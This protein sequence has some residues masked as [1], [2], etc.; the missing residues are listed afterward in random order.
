MSQVVR[1]D[2]AHANQVT[3]FDGDDVLDEMRWRLFAGA[4][5][6]RGVR[7]TLTLPV[8][9]DER[10][11]GTVN[12]Y[13]ASARAFVGHHE[14]LAK[15]FGAWACGAVSNADLGFRTRTEAEAAPQRLREQHVIDVA[16]GIVAAHLGVDVETALA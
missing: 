11:E 1:V 2:G 5:A 13:A 14:E 6:E 16:T 15:V 9:S 3:E 10:V 4:T 8:V 12:L 7:S